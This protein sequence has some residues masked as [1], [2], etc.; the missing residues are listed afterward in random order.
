MLLNALYGGA[1]GHAMLGRG[2]EMDD[3]RRPGRFNAGAVGAYRLNPAASLLPVWDRT[4]PV[5]DKATWRDPLVAEAYVREAIA[6]EPS[7]PTRNPPTFR[8]PSGALEDSFYMA[9]GRQ[10][11]VAGS[12]TARVLIVRGGRSFWSRAEDVA[13]LER[14]L[15]Q[16]ASVAV[17]SLPEATHF[18]HLDR[19]EDGRD[20][21]SAE[22][23]V[24]LRSGS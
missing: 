4:I 8:S 12:I 23:D 3:P 22:V 24:R 1:E 13:R 20:R 17:V 16:A 15:A 10:L 2:T 18:I 6:S 5:E 11:W 14:H 19:A 21:L 9:T 7:S